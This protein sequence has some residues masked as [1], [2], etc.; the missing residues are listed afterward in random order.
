MSQVETRFIKDLNVTTAKIAAGAVTDAKVAT[1]ID[2][3]KIGAGSVSNTEFG[4]LD[5]VTSGIQGQINA[6][7]PPTW[8]KE[9]L[10]LISGDITNQYI[11]LAHPIKA[12]SLSL[13]ISG[14]IQGE[15]VDYTISL[16]GGTGGNTRVTFGTPLATGGVSELVVGDVL[17]FQYQY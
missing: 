2:A 8:N 12:S 17:Y 5:G 9:K 14:L 13:M 1:G 4:Y 11:D 7:T 15:T 3:A 10:T 16:T 6:I